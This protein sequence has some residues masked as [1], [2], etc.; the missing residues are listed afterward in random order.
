MGAL[1]DKYC[2]VGVGET[3]YSRWSNRT[4]LSMACEAILK[5]AADAG[6]SV[7]EIDGITSYNVNDS[8]SNTAVASALG[9]RTNMGVD[10]IGG[11]NSIGHLIAQT[12]GLIEGGYCRNVAVFRSMN[13]RSGVRMGGQAPTGVAAVQTAS[14]GA[15]FN[16]PWGLRGAPSSFAM[17]AMAYLHQYG[18][19]TLNMAEVAVTHGYH[20][21]LNPKATRKDPITIEEHQASRWVTKPFRLLDC[22][23]ENDVA[24]A[25]IITS[26]ERAADLKQPPVYIMGGN[27][28]ASSYN[29]DFVWGLRDMSHGW[30]H[31]VRH[32]A[33][34]SAGIRVDDV[35][36][37]SMYDNFTSTPLKYL[38]Y[39]GFCDEG[40][41]GN[42]VKD[43][44]I[45]ID[46]ELPQNLSGGQHS[47][48]YTHGINFII[49]NTRQLRGRADDYCERWFEG[50][51]TFDR[52]K[53]CRQAKTRADRLSGNVTNPRF[54]TI[55]MSAGGGGSAQ[56]WTTILRR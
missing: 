14:G 34:G 56:G 15:Q 33:F 20:A 2:I 29:P 9:I 53:G 51:H 37:V 54:P 4:T 30:G 39:F 50:K 5:A 48:G 23:Q 7:D 52:S 10:I 22:C 31:Y 26:R 1:T 40:D 41:G 46:G 25:L 24:V 16:T 36:I 17:E 35:D 47:E 13:G 11:G 3:A 38:E 18:Y 28:R 32:R 42:F 8:T 45:R 27:A 19:S 21:S 12:I 44:R 55:A 6:L 43:G 49:E